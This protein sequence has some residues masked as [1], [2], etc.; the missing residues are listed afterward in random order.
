MKHKLT[1]IDFDKIDFSTKELDNGKFMNIKYNSDT[2]EFQ[3]PKVFIHEII[4]EDEKEYLILKIKA[5]QACKLFFDKIHELEKS[6]EDKFKQ[7]VQSVFNDDH[8]KV[9]V[10]F[11]FKKPT[12]K[13]YHD[14]QLFNYY[15]LCKGM[16]IICLL[17]CDK[18]WSDHLNIF[19]NLQVKEIMLLKK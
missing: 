4:K 6:F 9:K 5:N 18:L 17:Q 15:H 11:T 2:L 8:L 12:T 16:E 3:T 14:E 7:N 19:Y 1:E 10:P 13:V